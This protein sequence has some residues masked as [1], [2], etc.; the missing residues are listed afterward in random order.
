MSLLFVSCSILDES[1]L[2][3]SH[4]LNGNDTLIIS[5]V[6]DRLDHIKVAVS[7]NISDSSI[8][9]FF[10]G[11]PSGHGN[12]TPDTVIGEFTETISGDWYAGNA[13]VTIES[14]DTTVVITGNINLKG[15]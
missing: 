6:Q 4:T 7:G 14:L 15:F 3:E 13:Y 10:D 11:E 8:I 1:T 9:R 12:F 5:D 2:D